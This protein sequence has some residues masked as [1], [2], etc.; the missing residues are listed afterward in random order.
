M[1]HWQIILAATIGWLFLGVSATIIPHRSAAMRA[2]L[3]AWSRMSLRRSFGQH[4]KRT[5]RTLRDVER[6]YGFLDSEETNLRRSYF[7]LTLMGPFA[8][9]LLWSISRMKPE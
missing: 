7:G 4:A 2:K 5:R 6:A 1:E 8:F 3:I 9:L